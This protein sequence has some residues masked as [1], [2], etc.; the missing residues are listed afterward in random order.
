MQHSEPFIHSSWRDQG[1]GLLHE[2]DSYMKE[3]NVPETHNI[4]IICLLL[5]LTI[6]VIIK[7]YFDTSVQIVSF[8]INLHLTTV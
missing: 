2:N 1:V 7:C 5:R 6:T 3:F 8:Q 4:K